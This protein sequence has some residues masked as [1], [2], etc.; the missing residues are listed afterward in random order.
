MED[1]L[2]GATDDLYAYGGKIDAAFRALAEV[3]SSQGAEL[4]NVRAELERKARVED[5]ESFRRSLEDRFS[6][7][8][9]RIDVIE[10][11]LSIDSGG[12]G[13]GGGVGGGAGTSLSA[14][15]TLSM[16]DSTMGP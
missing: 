3:V 12:G 14:S 10:S 5:L 13:G 8:E 4:R 6:L 15:G 16:L 2:R 9:R 1:A 11:S 7:L